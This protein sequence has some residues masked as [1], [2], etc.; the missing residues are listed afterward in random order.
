MTM[1]D[2]VLIV[3]FEL[4]LSAGLPSFLAF[5]TGTVAV[6]LLCVLVGE[7]TMSLAYFINRDHY[8]KM[9]KEMVRHQNLSIKAIM[10]KDKESYKACNTV[11]N[12]AFGKSF[13][14]NIALFSAALWP[15]CFALAWMGLRFSGLDFTIPLL[16]VQVG[17][18]LI[19]VLT[20]VAV[21]VSFARWVRPR[22]WPFN[23]IAEAM[24]RNEDCGEEMMSW[25]DLMPRAPA[26]KDAQD[27]DGKTAGHPA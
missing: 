21:R 4:A 26:G 8:A 27:K 23:R 6:C 7:L 25:G 20:Y 13:F 9:R 17:Y 19:F 24:R 5:F 22:L 1:L 3:P 16:G 14:A 11:A 18:M 12:E 2:P 15:A 10:L